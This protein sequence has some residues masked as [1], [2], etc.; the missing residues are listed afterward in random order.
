MKTSLPR[1]AALGLFLALLG[2]CQGSGAGLPPSMGPVLPTVAGR[3]PMQFDSRKDA[4]LAFTRVGGSVTAT[5]EDA[6]WLRFEGDPATVAREH[7]AYFDHGYTTFRIELRSND[8]T[9][10]VKE[11]FV[12]EDSSGRRVSGSPTCY[13]GLGGLVEGKYFCSFNL[14]FRHVITLDLK[15]IRLTR[16]LDGSVVEWTFEAASCAPPPPTCPPPSPCDAPPP[17]RR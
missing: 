11:T 3:R 5:L 17:V 4:I 10:P 15:W 2:G 9:Q 6:A 14:S 12:L 7:K 8:F 13:D 1:L 16:P